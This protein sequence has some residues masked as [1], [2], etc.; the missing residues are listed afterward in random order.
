MC[1]IGY[2]CSVWELTILTVKPFLSCF[3]YSH[4]ST[5]LNTF[6]RLED[7]RANDYLE[8]FTLS[9]TSFKLQSTVE[10]DMLEQPRKGDFCVVMMAQRNFCLF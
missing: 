7:K 3:L 1:K 4:P 6:L 9:I 8:T 10:V 5:V 2:S